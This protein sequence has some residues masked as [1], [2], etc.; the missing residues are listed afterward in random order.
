MSKAWFG[1][2][3]LSLPLLSGCGQSSAAQPLPG[4]AVTGVVKLNGKP[5]I[6]ARL[7]YIPIEGTKGFGGHAF[8]DASGQYAIE[9]S[10]GSKQLPIGKYKIIV[11]TFR[12]PEDP[13]LAAQFPAP[14]GKPTTIPPIYGSELDT[15][16]TAMV[17]SGAG[18]ID[19]E[20]K[21]R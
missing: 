7:K 2:V 15:P 6:A 13:D 5:A 3:V 9:N 11:E 19:I 18:P 4:T 17:E 8:S 16:L 14:D 20:L 1:L 21:S 10:T 12:P